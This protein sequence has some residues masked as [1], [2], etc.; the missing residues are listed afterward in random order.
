MFAVVQQGG[1]Q[2][3]VREGE[4]IRVEL[5]DTVSPGDSFTIEDVLL[6]TEDG[7][8]VHIGKPT[9]EGAKVE[10]VVVQHGR[11]KKIRVFKKKRRKGYHKT[12]GHRQY[13]TDLKIVKISL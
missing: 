4:I 7:G 11:D 9:L 8:E 10:C 12:I 5:I 6:V 3:N 13:F 2:Y 1:K